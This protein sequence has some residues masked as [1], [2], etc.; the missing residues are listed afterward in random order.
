MLPGALLSLRV[1]SAIS[2]KDHVAKTKD[3]ERY[4][5]AELDAAINTKEFVD[6]DKS[7]SY[8]STEYNV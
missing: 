7:S 3:N 6:N 1:L 8:D 4:V 5:S 2:R